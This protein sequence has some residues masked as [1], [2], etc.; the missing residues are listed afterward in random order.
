MNQKNFESK[1][2]SCWK[3]EVGQKVIRVK[4]TIIIMIWDIWID[5]PR[6]K[7]GRTNHIRAFC[8]IQIVMICRSKALNLNIIIKT[9]INQN[10]GVN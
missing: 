5:S 9:K 4:A 8:I 6:L 10:L 1:N 3:M 2:G 7:F